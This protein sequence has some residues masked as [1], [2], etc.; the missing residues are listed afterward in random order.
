MS[1]NTIIPKQ[2]RTWLTLRDSPFDV[3]HVTYTSNDKVIIAFE[4]SSDAYY[5]MSYMELLGADT[6]E[7]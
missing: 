7:D 5:F 1:E 3:S 6:Y 2:I 4:Y